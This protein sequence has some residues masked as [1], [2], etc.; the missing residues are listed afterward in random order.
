[1]WTAKSVSI[2]LLMGDV[3]VI[4]SWECPDCPVSLYNIVLSWEKQSLLFVIQ[5]LWS[6][7]TS[8]FIGIIWCFSGLKGRLSRKKYNYLSVFL[9]LEEKILHYKLC[10]LCK[11]VKGH[12]LNHACVNDSLGCQWSF[13]LF[14]MSVIL[15]W[16]WLIIVLSIFRRLIRPFALVDHV[17]NFLQTRKR[18]AYFCVY[19][20]LIIWPTIAKRLVNFIHIAIWTSN[21]FQFLAVAS[22]YF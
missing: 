16:P 8:L 10:A 14:T 12:R 20:K 1:M 4:D 3:T 9:I 18:F 2:A 21:K 11:L 17:I 22:I 7:T 19:R 5:L 13:I 6:F 15:T